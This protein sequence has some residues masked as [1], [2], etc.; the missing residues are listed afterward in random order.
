M[1]AR[2]RPFAILIVILS[3]LDVAQNIVFAGS[4]ISCSTIS[5]PDPHLIWL[6]VRLPLPEGHFN[7]GFADV[8]LFCAA[9]ENLRRRGAALDVTLLPGVIAIA[10]GEALLATVPPHPAAIVAGVMNSLVLFLTAGYVVSEL[11]VRQRSTKTA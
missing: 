7:I 3:V 9:S 11:A 2:F 8:I 1:P 5:A 6:N 4:S 10:L